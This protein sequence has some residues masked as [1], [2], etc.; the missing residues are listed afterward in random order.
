MP[1][2]T[3]R[4][5][6]PEGVEEVL[7]RRAADLERARRRLLDLFASWGYRLV[8]P[9]FIEYLDSL[10]I[11]TGGDL[12]LQTFKLTDQ[13]SGRL[14]GVRADMTP[15]VARIDAH[16]LRSEEPARL[17]YLGTVLRAR[18][19]A[20]AGSRSPVQVGAELYGHAGI[21]SD[22]EVASL[23]IESL[24]CAGIETVHLDLGHVGVFRGIVRQAGFDRDTEARLHEALQRKA[25][26]EI[27]E[28]LATCAPDLRRA[29][30]LL[31][32][33]NG[34]V[35]VIGEARAA[36]AGSGEPV[37]AALTMLERLAGLLHARFPT[38]QLHVDLAELRGYHY[39]TGVVFA[40][41]TPGHG[42]EIARGGRYDQIGIDFGRARPAT[43]FSADLKTLVL[44]A[45][46][47]AEPEPGAILAPWS[48]G[49]EFHAAVAALRDA[50][51]RVILRLPDEY[52][53]ARHLECD[54]ELRM[55]NGR[56]VVGTRDREMS[57]TTK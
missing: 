44:L 13:L 2:T 6:L 34:G 22:C 31:A 38:L 32:D 42:Q 8:I 52:A 5:L 11:G 15:Q 40:A 16:H 25:R 29:L 19:E 1:V 43:G 12:D 4:W 10:L 53:G 55:E 21:E 47:D 23:M 18:P 51:E 54:R 17:C 36:L 45:G 35:E 30:A 27:E 14:L 24:H 26:A 46:R 37:D 20:V 41:F 39:H 9:P 33:L 56:W 49:A 48:D 50:G 7:P 3:D 28:Q 57:E